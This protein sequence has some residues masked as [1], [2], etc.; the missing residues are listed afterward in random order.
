MGLFDAHDHAREEVERSRKLKDAWMADDDSSPLPHSARHA[1]GGLRY[2][3]YDPAFRV[4]ARLS[5]FPEARVVT[6][7]TSTGREQQY[8]EHGRFEFEIGGERAALNAYRKMPDPHAHVH[9]HSREAGTLFVPFRDATSGRESYG[10]ARYLDLPE[11]AGDESEIDFNLA[12]NPYCAYSEAYTCP[13]PPRENWLT[14]A[15]RAGE[16]EFRPH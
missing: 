2:F 6:V 1:F 14:V 16:M 15:I 10:A 11:P 13:L 7:G 9:S 12:Y 4:R 3:P 5:R 8:L